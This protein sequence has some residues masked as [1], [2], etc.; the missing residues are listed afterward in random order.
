MK[1]KIRAGDE[2]TL[3]GIG[4]VAWVITVAGKYALVMYESWSDETMSREMQRRAVLVKELTF[5]RHGYFTANWWKP[6]DETAPT[7]I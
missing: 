2:V 1:T 3:R 6:I 4:A 7:N 5:K